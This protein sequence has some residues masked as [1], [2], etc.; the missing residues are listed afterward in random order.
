MLKP[1]A[2]E[3]TETRGIDMTPLMDVMF[4]LLIF[5]ALT[6]AFLQPQLSLSLPQ[7]ERD[8]EKNEN[9][10]IVSLDSN[11][12]VFIDDTPCAA[13][14]EAARILAALIARNPNARTLLRADKNV[15]YGDFFT[16]ITMAEKAGITTL[17]LAYDEE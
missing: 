10:I 8:A 7:A 15:R 17:N 3:E 16:L 12:K 13:I 2:P 6:S 11:G 14:E 1:F 4:M 9:D 5:F